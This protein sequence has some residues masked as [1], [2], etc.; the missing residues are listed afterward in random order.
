[1]QRTNGKKTQTMHATVAVDFFCGAGGMTNGLIKAGLHVLAG[2]EASVLTLIL[3]GVAINSLATALTTLALNLAPNPYAS[4][5]L[6][7]WLLGSLA[8]RSL[9]HVMLALPPM[10]LGGALLIG[11][12]R[13][14][15]ALTLGEDV[16][17]SLGVNLA[18]LR[19][20]LVA[21]TALAVG[22]AVAVTGAVAFVGLIVPHLLRPLVGHQ[23]SRLLAASALGGAALVLAADILVRLV[24]TGV[25]LKLGVVTALMGAPFF[26]HLVV[27]TRRALT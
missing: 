11:Q 1:M 16:A 25:E 13:A 17:A 14:L 22:A 9:D 19:L 7:F 24:P 18:A 2:R 3:A 8:D 15:D 6:F 27:R 20:G 10:V 5:E 21:G 4:L 12:G 23:P 26:L